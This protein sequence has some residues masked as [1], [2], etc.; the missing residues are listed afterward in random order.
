[1]SPLLAAGEAVWI[2]GAIGAVV[3]LVLALILVII[4]FSYFSLWI[5]SFSTGAGITMFDLIGMTFRKVN[6]RV[7]VKSK[8]MAVQAG[9]GEELGITSRALEA[10]Y[11]AGGNVPLVIRALIA[12]S[13]AKIIKLSFTW[14]IIIKEF[15]YKRP[16]LV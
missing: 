9:L 7:I 11:L 6:A 16:C 14:K 15:S 13:K 3:L 4:F 10:H 2:I 1:M 5:Q 8:I 12:A